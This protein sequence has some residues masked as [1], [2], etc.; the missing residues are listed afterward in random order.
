[1]EKIR[2]RF[3]NFG[4]K[5]RSAERLLQIGHSGASL[6]KGKEFS[7]TTGQF[8]K[9]DRAYRRHCGPTAVTNL[10][11][12]LAGEE[13]SPVS[14]KPEEVFKRIAGIG[15][16]RLIY[17]NAD[18]LKV[19]GGTSDILA[20]LFILASL[21]AYG[22]N[23]YRARGPFPATAGRICSELDKGAILY[24]EVHH[25]PVYGNHHMLC[26]GYRIADG[27]LMLR[28]A[29]GWVNG[30]HELHAGEERFALCTAISKKK[31]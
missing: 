25:H 27:R 11:Y 24:M 30:I 26:Y 7:F 31:N 6:W 8:A 15:K 16:R 4:K 18:F 10:V 5:Q 12:T 28:I 23:G 19:F 1:M 13:G 17:M 20:P 2:D 21:K 22:I 3:R 29:D 14:E 9:L